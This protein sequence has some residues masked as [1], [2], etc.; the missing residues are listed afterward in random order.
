MDGKMDEGN[1][2]QKRLPSEE[3]MK[4]SL[5][6]YFGFLHTKINVLSDMEYTRM[7]KAY[8]KGWDMQFS[9]EEIET[10]LQDFVNIYGYI[11][12][13]GNGAGAKRLMRGTSTQEAMKLR[14]GKEVDQILSTTKEEQIAKRFCEYG[15][16]ALIRIEVQPDLPYVYV[17][18]MRDENVANE[19]EV[20]ILPFSKVTKAQLTS[21]WQGYKYY[22]VTIEKQ[23]LPEVSEERL[24]ELKELCVN[25]YEDFVKQLEEYRGLRKDYSTLREAVRLTIKMDEYKSNMQELLKGLCRQREKDIDLQKQETIKT[26]YQHQEAEATMPNEQATSQDEPDHTHEEEKVEQEKEQLAKLEQA[27]RQLELIVEQ[28]GE[29]IQGNTQSNVKSIVHTIQ[30]Y[31]NMANVLGIQTW[32]TQNLEQQLQEK[33]K[34]I[35]AGVQTKNDKQQ[36]EETYQNLSDR[37]LHYEKAQELVKTMPEM[38]KSYEETSWLELKEV[39]NDKVQKMIYQT[40]CTRLNE[41][42]KLAISQKDNFLNKLLGQTPL[43][44]AK[45]ENIEAQMRYAAKKMQ[46]ANPQN[47]VRQMLADMYQCAYD[48]NG[49][50]LT[51]QMVQMERAMR[52]IF[53]NIPTQ[54]E[55][56]QRASAKQKRGLPAKTRKG[57]FSWVRNRQEAKRLDKET[58]MLN[59]QTNQIKGKPKMT[60]SAKLTNLYGQYNQMLE[61]IG[62]A[63]TL[64]ETQKETTIKLFGE[65]VSGEENDRDYRF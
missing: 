25:G 9:K 62:Q 56:I 23:E 2:Y 41:Q 1:M 6:R 3:E 30:K 52:S 34:K 32:N 16:A 46:I 55:L 58:V 19:E 13:Q 12:E 38:Q 11:Y 50:K 28:K 24:A 45:V 63:V 4:A 27:V 44:Y 18:Q 64:P 35:T 15:Q 47:S 5:D 59:Q 40:T 43:K 53:S 36:I 22:D 37:G 14:E 61:K 60:A 20:L 26:V 31:R 8:E 17:E 33:M 29:E 51:P 49:G 57:L 10:L 7:I 48:I 42:K 39:L 65:K 21:H 54:E